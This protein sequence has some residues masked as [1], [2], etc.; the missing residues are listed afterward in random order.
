MSIPHRT[1]NNPTEP[2]EPTAPAPAIATGPAP[3]LA[4]PPTTSQRSMTSRVPRTRTSAAW[5]AICALAL[6]VV[7]LIIFMMQNTGNVEVTF[8]WMHG[9]LPLA[10]ALLIAGV[11]VTMVAL[12]VGSARI[13]QLHRL[14]ARRAV[15][16]NGPDVSEPR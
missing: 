7:A 10:L 16:S 11:G 15:K 1:S 12:I 4:S 3:R 2:T 5:I 14:F 9:T 13:T 8:L 6:A